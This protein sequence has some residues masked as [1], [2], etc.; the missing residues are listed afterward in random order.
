MRIRTFA[1]AAALVLTLSAHA[2]RGI[3][4]PMTRAVL[5]VYEK[6]LQ[7]D[8]SD[9]ET[10]MARANE[11]YMHSEYLRSLNDVDN[12]LKYIPENKKAERFDALLL[13][14][15]IYTET[16]RNAEALNDLNSAVALMPSSY[17]ALYLRANTLYSLGRYDEAS[18]DYKRLQRINQR[19]P[20]ALVG[21]ARIAVK[22]NNLGTANELL[23]QAV[24]M[25]P[26]NS[27]YYVRRADVRK[28]MGLTRDAVDDLVLAV[29]INSDDSRAIQHLVDLGKS[30]YPTVIAGLT[31]AIQQAPR[32]GMFPYIR[33]VIAQAHY[34][35]KAALDDFKAIN[36]KQL[37]NYHGIYASMA[38]CQLALGRYDEALQ[39]VETAIST[40]A[41]SAGHSL[42]KAQILR[43]LGRPAEAFDIALKASVMNG[44]SNEALVEMGLCRA[45]EGKWQEA[46]DLFGEASLDNPDSP[47]L[48]MLRAW[49]LGKHLNQPVAA[50]GFYGQ[51]VDLE[52]WDLDNVRSL[53]GFAQL[54]NGDRE[55]AVKWIENILATVTDKDGFVHYMGACFY[56][57]AG[58]NER[59]IA[60]AHKA[61]E[62]GYANYYEWMTLNDGL[63]TVALLRDD[64]S[65]L[66]LIEKYKYLWD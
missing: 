58:D 40:D 3:D 6:Q 20:D 2:Q 49:V 12:A 1:A 47:E 18:A 60:L 62:L 66:R 44:G 50:A 35:Y 25:D 34:N 24:A 46:A 26:N 23:D 10:W 27:E 19:S 38:E 36:D 55:Q 48:L 8:P 37:Y 21:L 22:E 7:E 57:V 52:G 28:Q 31:S 54:L 41:N 59:A 33:G 45:G 43:A 4:N 51:V 29:S 64:L 13:R 39:N 61:M 63:C 30:D 5:Q 53:K 9:W 17:V 32:V 11:Y 42:P 15:N 16:G 14:A 65:F 56:T